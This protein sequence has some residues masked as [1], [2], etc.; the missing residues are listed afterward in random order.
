MNVCNKI[1]SLLRD[2]TLFCKVNFD[3][4]EMKELPPK[5]YLKYKDSNNDDQTVLIC[6]NKQ[7]INNNTEYT[8]LYE[9]DGLCLFEDKDT[10]SKN[11]EYVYVK[12]QIFNTDELLPKFNTIY[13]RFSKDDKPLLPD[14]YIFTLLH[15]LAHCIIVIYTIGLDHKYKSF[16]H[17]KYHGPIFYDNFL[18][19]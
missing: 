16:D 4:I 14:K 9:I 18:K 17:H 11:T 3:D 15:E 5:L 7:Y 6:Q 1:I 2:E 12:E 10:V 13:I 8:K 19:F